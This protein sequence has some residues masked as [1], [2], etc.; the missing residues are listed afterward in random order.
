MNPSS[1]R[2]LP[3]VAFANNRGNDGSIA[4]KSAGHL[5]DHA[6]FSNG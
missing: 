4:V 6:R 2:I 1:G 5:E 3:G